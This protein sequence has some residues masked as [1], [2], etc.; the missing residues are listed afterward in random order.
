MSKRWDRPKR[1]ELDTNVV[2]GGR[3]SAGLLCSLQ[4]S[5]P[6]PAETGPSAV[7]GLISTALAHQFSALSLTVG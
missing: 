7:S 3:R 4:L 5:T 1:L 6:P 2:V